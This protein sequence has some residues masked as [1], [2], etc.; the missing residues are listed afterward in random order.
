MHPQY[1]RQGAGTAIYR[2][3]FEQLPQPAVG[4]LPCTPASK[5]VAS[6]APPKISGLQKDERLSRDDLH[7][8]GRL[9]A[10]KP[11]AAANPTP[12]DSAAGGR[13]AA[14]AL[15][16]SWAGTS[17]STTPSTASTRQT[18]AAWHPQAGCSATASGCWC[19][20]PAFSLTAPLYI[21]AAID[22]DGSIP[23]PDLLLWAKAQAA[24]RGIPRLT[25]HFFPAGR[26]VESNGTA[27]LS[28]QWLCAGPFGR[29]GLHQPPAY[30][31]TQKSLQPIYQSSGAAATLC[32]D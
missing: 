18:A 22:R 3:Y 24:L 29:R 32:A 10:A 27:I 15:R 4:R 1:Q 25:A 26:S 14:A 21:A 17:T 5:N 16:S 8:C 9:P 7:P 11:F 28:K 23:R 6:A 30:K 13:T 12:A 31:I 20:A 19:S 2:R